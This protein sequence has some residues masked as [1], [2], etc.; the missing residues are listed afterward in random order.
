[1]ASDEEVDESYA[2]EDDLDETGGQVSNVNQQVDGSSDAEESQRLEEDDDY[3]PEERKKKERE[4]T[5]ST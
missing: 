1:M 2:G 3:E 5:K 4:K